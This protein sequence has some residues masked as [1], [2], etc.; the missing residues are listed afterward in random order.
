MFR[1]C[2]ELSMSSVVVSEVR[3]LSLTELP[4]E[5][6]MTHMPCALWDSPLYHLAIPGRFHTLTVFMKLVRCRLNVTGIM[7][8]V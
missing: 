3:E 2:P 7:S 5:S 8:V 4:M 1:G 6:W